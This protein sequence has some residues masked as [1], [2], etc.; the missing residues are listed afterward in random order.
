MLNVTSLSLTFRQL[1]VLAVRLHCQFKRI[2]AAY[3]NAMTTTL[4]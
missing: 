1:L 2:C 4:V 3:C